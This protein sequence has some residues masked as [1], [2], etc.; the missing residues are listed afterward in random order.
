M[1]LGFCAEAEYRWMRHD[2][3]VTAASAQPKNLYDNNLALFEE[4]FG[5]YDGAVLP[6]VQ[7]LLVNDI[8]WK[9]NSRIA[10]STHVGGAAYDEALARMGRL[11]ERVDT[12]LIMT[13]PTLK[14][15]FRLFVLGLKKAVPLV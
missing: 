12:R 13:H 3:G 7:E 11:L 5:R 15:D 4:L 1:K 10:L 2:E 9:M 14:R 6:Y 8:A